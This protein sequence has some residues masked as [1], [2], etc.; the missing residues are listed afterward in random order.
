M[1]SKRK[2]PFENNSPRKT[3]FKNFL[4]IYP[5]HKITTLENLSVSHASLTAWFSENK[6]Y[7]DNN[8][9]SYI[10]KQQNIWIFLNPEGNKVLTRSKNVY[11][12]INN[13]QKVYIRVYIRYNA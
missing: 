2:T 3:S 6:T 7:R 10:V 9:Y 4:K 11:Q 1:Y 8:R 12:N 5:E 13:K